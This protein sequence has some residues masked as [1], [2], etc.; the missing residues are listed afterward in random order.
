MIETGGLEIEA[1]E[2]DLDV[3]LD[4]CGILATRPTEVLNTLVHNR[5]AKSL[6]MLHLLVQEKDSEGISTKQKSPRMPLRTMKDNI[7]GSSMTRSLDFD[8]LKPRKKVVGERFG[9]KQ[10]HVGLPAFKEV[11]SQELVDNSSVSSESDGD[12]F[13]KINEEA[14]EVDFT[15]G[16]SE[17]VSIENSVSTEG[18]KLEENHVSNNSEE[19]NHKGEKKGEGDIKNIDNVENRSENLIEIAL[20]TDSERRE[21]EDQFV[22]IPD[23]SG[24]QKRSTALFHPSMKMSLR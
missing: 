10:I 17:N 2:T 11:L 16:T 5:K 19:F 3:L 23:E 24:K 9:G 13:A 21:E 6:D 22:T 20:H 14:S 8:D 7:V 4:S 18:Q 15:V 12:V 1:E